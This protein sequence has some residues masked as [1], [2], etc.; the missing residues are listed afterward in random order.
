MSCADFFRFKNPWLF[1]KEAPRQRDSREQTNRGDH[2]P[3]TEPVRHDDSDHGCRHETSG[4]G[5]HEIAV[6]SRAGN[7]RFCDERPA[8]GC[9]SDL[10][11][12]PIE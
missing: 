3:L 10:F 11:I 6:P 5:E 8:A 9:R 4:G 12:V 7:V 2:R 1:V